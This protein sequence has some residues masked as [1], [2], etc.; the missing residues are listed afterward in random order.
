M[1]AAKGEHAYSLR[2]WFS[3]GYEIRICFDFGDGI[4]NKRHGSVPDAEN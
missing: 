2:Y 3:I 1:R 4:R